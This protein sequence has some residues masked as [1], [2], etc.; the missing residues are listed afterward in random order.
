MFAHVLVLLMFAESQPSSFE[1]LV[2]QAT[3]A[4]DGKRLDE[5]LD[6]YKKALKQKPNWEQGLWE[7]GSIAY[8]TDHFAE[9]APA[10]RKLATLK[11]DLVPAW[12]MDGLCEFALHDYNAALK[13]LHQ[14]ELL[15]FRE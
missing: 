6:L 7:Y 14:T 4:R 8:D 12:T 13:S 3:A 15:G 10:F 9:C 2:R 1:A 5:A 11:P